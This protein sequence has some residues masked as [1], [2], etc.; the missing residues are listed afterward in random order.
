[1]AYPAPRRI[2]SVFDRTPAPATPGMTT[3][4]KFATPPAPERSMLSERRRAIDQT[5][6][7]WR[8]DPSIGR[9]PDAPYTRDQPASDGLRYAAND[10][11]G[12]MGSLR[13]Q[14]TGQHDP[15]AWNGK[16]A[17]TTDSAPAINWGQRDATERA[18]VQRRGQIQA[19]GTAAEAQAMLTADGGGY[20]DTTAWEQQRAFNASRPI[21]NAPAY[22][23]APA[24]PAYMPPTVSR[25]ETTPGFDQE[26]YRQKYIEGQRGD[27]QTKFEAERQ[28]VIQNYARSGISADSPAVAHALSQLEAQR[29]QELDRLDI[30]GGRE[31]IKMASDDGFRRAGQ[32]DNYGLARGG[33]GLSYNQDQRAQVQQDT[34]LPGQR[35]AQDVATAGAQQQQTFAAQE[36]PIKVNRMSIDSYGAQANVDA[37]NAATGIA[38]SDSALRQIAAPAEREAQQQRNDLFARLAP[39]QVAQ[40]EQAIAQGQ[41]AL[42][43]GQYDVWLASQSPWIQT[44]LRLVPGLIQAGA[45]VAARMK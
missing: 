25:Y 17:P 3:L 32:I 24:A 38:H 8:P 10:A 44:A 34:L 27:M 22:T 26:A 11:P 7:A 37:T 40:M 20:L 13:P 30:E 29:G 23:P 33:L 6:P 15:N 12:T 1:M 19:A 45:T 9:I 43:S 28:A 42:T 14:R 18:A 36:Q 16:Y 35:T 5:D 39:G 41:Q 4:G 2:Q 21:P 31:A